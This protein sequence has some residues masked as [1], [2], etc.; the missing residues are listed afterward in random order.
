MLKDAKSFSGFSVDD[1]EKAENFYK[2]TLGLNVTKEHHTIDLLSLH[3]A[4]G[5]TA[6]IGSE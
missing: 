1:I 5:G 3:L 4:G 2:G 6:V